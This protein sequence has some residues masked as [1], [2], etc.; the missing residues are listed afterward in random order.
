LFAHLVTER[1]TAE[2]LQRAL[3]LLGSDDREA[4]SRF[5]SALVT[6]RSAD[7]VHDRQLA[8]AA[9]RSLL[10][11]GSAPAEPASAVRRTITAFRD[12]CDP[13]VRA[14]LPKPK[15]P[16]ARN[17]PVRFTLADSPGALP[18]Y[19]AAAL[20]GGAVLVAYGEHG[21]RLLTMD[22]RV[23]ARWDVPA[24]SLVVADH[25]G[26]ALLISVSNT[27][28]TIRQL[29]LADRRIRPWTTLPLWTILPSYDG[30]VL[31]VVDDDGLAFLDTLSARPK[32]LWREL[33]RTHAV[34]TIN[35]SP[36]ALTALVSIPPDEWAPERRIELLYWEL[37]SLAM[38][39]RRSLGRDE[40]FKQPA[41]LPGRLVTIGDEGLIRYGPQKLV[42]G[43]KIDLTL[44]SNGEALSLML[45]NGVMEIEVKDQLV[46]T[47]DRPDT[48]RPGL[49]LHDGLVTVWTGDG[50]LAV[51]DSGRREVL[52]NFRTVL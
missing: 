38:R 35:R 33:D 49:R 8:T 28:Q 47:V 20:R 27:L 25:G 14:D 6:L 3:A 31:T 1:P 41:A 26:T 23:R 37:P 22:G 9:L 51:I 21:V 18:V 19:D 39:L 43:Q 7:P 10:R 45:G 5:V 12:R 24:H 52:A 16:A 42:E 46:A 15:P 29:E 48:R 36:E 44:H 40:D 4:Q 50:R 17:E 32:V 34:R 2:D 30:S 11:D 13:L